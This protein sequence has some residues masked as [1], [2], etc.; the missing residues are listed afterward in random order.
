MKTCNK[1]NTPKE[2]KEFRLHKSG[3]LLGQCKECERKANTARRNK[4]MQKVIEVI[5]K[6]G[7]KFTASIKPIDG[8]R[9]ASHEE[10]TTVLFFDG[11]SRDEARCAFSNYAD[12]PMT[13]IHTPLV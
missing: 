3:Y 2:E 12:V 9:R 6:N 11:L 10:S 5:T 7:R 13:G 4:K 1:C 8:A